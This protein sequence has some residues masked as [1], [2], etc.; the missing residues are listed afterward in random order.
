MTDGRG[1]GGI[2]FGVTRLAGFVIRCIAAGL[3]AAETLPLSKFTRTLEMATG[4]A[5]PA[6]VVSLPNA[7]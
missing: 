7:S 2:P 5:I 6:A 4:V 1:A 3:P